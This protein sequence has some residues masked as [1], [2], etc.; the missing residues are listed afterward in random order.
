MHKISQYLLLQVL[1]EFWYWNHEKTKKVWTKITS[2]KEMCI[3]FLLDLYMNFVHNFKY[4]FSMYKKEDDCINKYEPKL[5]R[6][7]IKRLIFFSIF[8]FFLSILIMIYKDN[9]KDDT[10]GSK[11]IVIYPVAITQRG[12]SEIF[13]FNYLLELRKLW[14]RNEQS[15]WPK[16]QTG[17]T[18]LKSFN[19]KL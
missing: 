10:T 14:K 8:H 3:P 17:V 12:A 7:M 4:S 13:N 9:N 2:Y 1:R 11:L 5:E 15:L 6:K 18:L 19:S 16:G